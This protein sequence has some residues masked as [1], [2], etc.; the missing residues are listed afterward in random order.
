MILYIIIA[1]LLLML[2]ISIVYCLVI[3]KRVSGLSNDIESFIKTGKLIPYSTKEGRFSILHNNVVE[4]ENKLLIEKSNSAAKDKENTDFI[5][6]IS[7]QLKTPLAGLRLYCELEQTENPS[8]HVEK[9]LILIDKMEKLVRELL[10][11]QKIK[12][13]GYTMNFQM[14]EV[15][16]IA[17]E[18]ISSMRPNFPQKN[19]TVLGKG[20]MR[21]DCSWLGEAIGNVIKNASEHTAQDGEIAVEIENSNNFLTVTVK[22]NGGGVPESEISKLFSRFHKTENSAKDSV[23]IGLSITKAITEKHH[24]TVMA[25]NNG[26]GLSVT[27]CF[28]HIDGQE[29]I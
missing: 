29:K 4:L 25:A 5:A 16:T 28:P 23:G 2:I 9:E 18:C 20:E 1:A 10:R 22:D 14:H 11:L 7:H 3:R 8:E 15:S 17:A 21:C 26:K 6:D 19:Y 13:G 24:G 12:S 27:M